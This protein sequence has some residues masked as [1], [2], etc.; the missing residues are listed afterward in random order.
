M[1]SAALLRESGTPAEYS[2]RALPVSLAG[3]SA[4]IFVRNSTRAR[5]YVLAVEGAVFL[6]SSPYTRERKRERGGERYRIE[7]LSSEFTAPACD[8]VK[9]SAIR[10]TYET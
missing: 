9:G 3:G 10:R 5:A 1:E 8:A 6:F 4:F 7:R 2:P